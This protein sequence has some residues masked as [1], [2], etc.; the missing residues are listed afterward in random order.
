MRVLA[1]LCSVCKSLIGR[2]MLWVG[3]TDGHHQA[4]LSGPDVACMSLIVSQTHSQL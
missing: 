4:L 3:V 1:D 2:E